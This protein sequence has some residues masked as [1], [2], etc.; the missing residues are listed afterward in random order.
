MQHTSLSTIRDNYVSANDYPAST[1]ILLVQ[2]S[3]VL[4]DL[5]LSVSELDFHKDKIIA[6]KAREASQISHIGYLNTLGSSSQSEDTNMPSAP[7]QS[8]P[9]PDSMSKSCSPT[10]N[11]EFK[12]IGQHSI[13]AVSP[14][15]NEDPSV[16]ALQTEQVDHLSSSGEKVLKLGE[17]LLKLF[18]QRALDTNNPSSLREHCSLGTPGLGSDDFG[19]SSVTAKLQKGPIDFPSLTRVNNSMSDGQA[20]TVSGVGGPAV[21]ESQNCPAPFLS[22]EKNTQA[23]AYQAS[24][25]TNDLYCKPSSRSRQLLASGHI[26]E[27]FTHASIETLEHGQAQGVEIL[28]KLE[29]AFTNPA[30]TRNPRYAKWLSSIGNVQKQATRTKTIIGVVGNTGAGKSSI[31]NALLDEERLVPTNCVR[32]CTA[33]A[34]EI[35]YND[36]DDLYHAEIDFIAAEDWQKELSI[37]FKD[38]LDGSGRVSREHKDES[39]EAGLAYAKI[40]AVYPKMTHEDIAGS[41]IDDLMRHSNVA[42]LLGTRKIF[43]EDNASNFYKRLQFYVDSKEKTTGENRK[44]RSPREMECW[45]LI[46]VVRLFVNSPALSTGAI[47]VDLPGVHDSNQ[48]RA[49]VAEDYMK[50]CT[51]LWIVAPITRAV[52]DKAAKSLLGDSFKRQLKLDGRFTSITFICSKADDISV[53]EA[54]DSLGLEEEVESGW[55]ESDQLGCRIED[56]AARIRELKADIDYTISALTT[57][58]DELD[59]WEDLQQKFEAGERV[60]VPRGFLK[61]RKNVHSALKEPRKR[62]K[63]DSNEGPAYHFP[64]D[65]ASASSSG[66]ESEE[67]PEPLGKEQISHMI[68]GLKDVRSEGRRAKSK[69][70]EELKPVQEEMGQLKELLTEVDANIKSQCIS[71][72]NTYAKEAI[73]DDFAAGVKELDQEIAEEEDALN[74]DPE[75]YLRD[76]DEVAQNLSVFCVSSRAYQRLQG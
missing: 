69:L 58:G 44:R 57:T 73:R 1:N 53:V 36:V 32:A 54:K 13:I 62:Q 42:E 25:N 4:S 46:K 2:D 45:P 39:S 17:K 12:H 50:N 67:E 49:A 37:L 10:A 65:N 48:A 11:R 71:A 28:K 16:V 38:L 56:R 41:S 21:E 52:D 7:A 20:R 74:F 75:A 8:E 55:E 59:M 72:R 70:E 30:V 18:E 61:K 24:L 6:L 31:I 19:M 76:Y 22:G 34:T 33:V 26:P 14:A 3:V 64:D 60:Y 51:G 40:K 68:M 63:S 43:S 47:I 35:S 27:M 23:S 66:S 9:R 5:S 29:D 15:Q